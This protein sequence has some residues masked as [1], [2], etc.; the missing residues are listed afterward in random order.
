M[1]RASKIRGYLTLNG[2]EFERVRISGWGGT[3]PIADNSTE[4]GKN[5]NRRVEMLIEN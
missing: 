3:R 5:K 1:K 2:V 4:E